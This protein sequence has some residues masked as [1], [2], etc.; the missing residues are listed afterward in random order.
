[1]DGR[2]RGV[3]DDGAAGASA[4]CHGPEGATPTAAENPILAG[5]YPDYLVKA[6]KDY[7]SG[8]RSNP[9]MQG[10]AAQLSAKDMEG[11]AAFFSSQKSSLHDQR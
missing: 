11:L 1:M 8:K 5:Q 2:A 7:K 10:F 3:G 9:I 4:A 6:L